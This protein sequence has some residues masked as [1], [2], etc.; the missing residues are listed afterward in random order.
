MCFDSSDAGQPPTTPGLGVAGVNEDSVVP[1]LEAIEVTQGRELAPHRDEG[2][3]DGILGNTFLNRWDVAVEPDRRLLMDDAGVEQG[4][5]AGADLSTFGRNL[6]AARDKGYN[7]YVAPEMEYFYFRSAVEPIPLDQASY[8]DLTPSDEATP[9]PNSAASTAA[10]TS[11]VRRA[12]R[13]SW[14]A[15]WKGGSRRSCPAP[16]SSSATSS[17]STSGSATR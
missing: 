13:T 8:F 12:P 3:L 5:L 15:T 4:P 14:A 6:A 1:R 2:C 11:A 17:A 9:G 7:F 16:P 10:I